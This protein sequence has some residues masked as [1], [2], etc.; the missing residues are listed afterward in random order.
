[1]VRDTRPLAEPKGL[2]VAAAYGGVGIKAQSSAVGRADILVA[3]PGRLSDLLRRGQVRL[4]S[5]SILVL[6]EADRMLDMGFLPDVD[7]IVRRLPK[8]RQTV[9][10]SATLDGE[11]ARLAQRYTRH[12]I[13]HE[14][15]SNQPTVDESDHRFLQVAEDGKVAALANLIEA[16]PGRTLVFVRTKRGADRLVRRLGTHGIHALGM[17]GD[18]N[19]VARERALKRFMDGSVQTLVATDV[20]ARG[21]DVEDIARVVNFDPPEDDKG[22]V[23]RVG[24]T[25]RAGRTGQG[26]TLVLPEQRADVSRMAARLQLEDHFRQG[27]MEVAPPRMVYASRRGR[28]SLLHGRPG[29]GR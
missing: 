23:H 22:Y 13:R 5:I 11:V 24:R 19:Q 25:A 18:L 9:F 29:R 2:K 7:A 8:E 28:R 6:D 16:E 20:A 15:R 1:V 26:V 4:D 10:L 14:V 27:R 17:H 3:T 21:L 12:P